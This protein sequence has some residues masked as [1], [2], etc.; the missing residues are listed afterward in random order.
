MLLVV[1]WGLV[2]AVFLSVEIMCNKWMMVS[3]GINGD[4]SGMFFLLV[5]GTI[6]TIC[7]IVTTS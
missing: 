2:G 1:L 6:G 5:E 7:L 3:R 4:I